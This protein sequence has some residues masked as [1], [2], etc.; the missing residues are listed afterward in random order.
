MQARMNILPLGTASL[1]LHSLL[2]AVNTSNWQLIIYG[3]KMGNVSTDNSY[4]LVTQ[5]P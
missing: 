5:V 1:F 3:K 2:R 4:F